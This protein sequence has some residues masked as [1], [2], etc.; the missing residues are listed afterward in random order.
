MS[1][2]ERRLSNTSFIERAPRELV[3]EMREKLA[4]S[5]ARRDALRSSRERLASALGS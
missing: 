5:A 1:D 4:A 3:D 2:L